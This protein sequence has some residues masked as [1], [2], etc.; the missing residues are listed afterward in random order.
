MPKQIPPIA[1]GKF[2]KLIESLGW[3]HKR[4]SGSHIMYAHQIRKGRVQFISNK[5]EVAPYI[6]KQLL[7]YMDMSVEDYLESIKKSK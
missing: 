1:R 6:V 3:Y 2:V 7:D 5:K 4:T